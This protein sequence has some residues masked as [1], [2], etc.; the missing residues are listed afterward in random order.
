MWWEKCNAEEDLSIIGNDDN[1]GEESIHDNVIDF[2]DDENGADHDADNEDDPD[3]HDDHDNDEEEDD[4]LLDKSAS[5]LSLHCKATLSWNYKVGQDDD[6]VAAAA[7]DDDDY[8][9]VAA[10]DAD[11]ADDGFVHNGHDDHPRERP[12]SIFYFVSQKSHSQIGLAR[13]PPT[14]NGKCP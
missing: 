9:D 12:Q 11:D 8:D 14:G 4:T 13:S 5:N 7:G 6:D 2:D 10:D 1:V 3:E